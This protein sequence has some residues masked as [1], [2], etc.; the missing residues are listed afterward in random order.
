MADEDQVEKDEYPGN[1]SQCRT[2][3]GNAHLAIPLPIAIIPPSDDKQIPSSNSPQTL[4]W[5]P[6]LAGSHLDPSVALFARQCRVLGDD[7][8][9]G[10]SSTLRPQG[11]SRDGSS[12][13]RAAGCGGA[14]QAGLRVS[15]GGC[16]G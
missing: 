1:C 14:G 6:F 12:E 8:L 5:H 15:A 4:D 9:D 2:S 3:K 16:C 10:P 7:G 13:Q 11:R